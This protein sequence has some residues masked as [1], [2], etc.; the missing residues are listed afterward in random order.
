MQLPL[1]AELLDRI[2]TK[3]S[4]NRK[5]QLHVSTIDL[6]YA[7]GQIELHKETAKQCVAA[8][9]EGKATLHY[10]FRKGFYGLADMPVVFQTKIDK[11][12]NYETPRRHNSCHSGYRR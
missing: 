2:S 4:G 6:E 8:I 1:L 3:I 5:A 7:I 11:V 9:V 12:L 10:R